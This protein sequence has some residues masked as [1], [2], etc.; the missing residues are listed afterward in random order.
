MSEYTPNPQDTIPVDR[1]RVFEVL[2]SNGVD[3]FDEAVFGRLPDDAV[4]RSALWVA[5]ENNCMTV[6]Q[7]FKAYLADDDFEKLRALW[8]QYI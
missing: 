6:E 8:E 2:K 1:K 7:F 4:L 5:K 3:T